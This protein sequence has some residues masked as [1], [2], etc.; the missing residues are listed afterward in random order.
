MKF[1]YISKS[2]H[3]NFNFKIIYD[4]GTNSKDMYPLSEETIP[5]LVKNTLFNVLYRSANGLLDPFETF[6]KEFSKKNCHKMH[7]IATDFN[8][9]LLDHENYKKCKNF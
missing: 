2:I 9:N 1:Q 4:L 5:N 6:L 3:K 7:H 8:L